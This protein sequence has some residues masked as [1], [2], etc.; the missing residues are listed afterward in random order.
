MEWKAVTA[1]TNSVDH[2]VRLSKLLDR[3]WEVLWSSAI[4]N[5]W[6]NEA[7][8]GIRTL[9]YCLTNRFYVQT[10]I[11]WKNWNYVTI[12]FWDGWSWFCRGNKNQ[13]W[14]ILHRT[15]QLWNWKAKEALSL[16][17]E[18]GLDMFHNLCI[19]MQWTLIEYAM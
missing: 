9:T 16:G 6:D 4:S 1:C 11:S 2:F 18:R 17:N 7:V 14:I 13:I 19:L 10:Y 12:I 15:P 3:C 5:R 8:L